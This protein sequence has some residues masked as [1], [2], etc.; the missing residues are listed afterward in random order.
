VIT[1]FNQIFY[2][3]SRLEASRLKNQLKT[4]EKK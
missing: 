4:G 1:G 3:A 2:A